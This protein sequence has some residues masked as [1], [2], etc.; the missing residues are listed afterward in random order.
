MDSLNKE[1]FSSKGTSK[2]Q[3]AS[4]VERRGGPFKRR[5]KGNDKTQNAIQARTPV[6]KPESM[7]MSLIRIHARKNGENSSAQNSL[8]P[9]SKKGN[10]RRV[11]AEKTLRLIF[12]VPLSNFLTALKHL[13]EDQ[14]YHAIM[15]RIEMCFSGHVKRRLTYS[16][17]N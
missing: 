15:E 14:I 6:S 1:M 4:S 10:S 7:F 11:N 17:W 3:K 9:I 5:R 16:G 12:S 13:M 8:V 2:E